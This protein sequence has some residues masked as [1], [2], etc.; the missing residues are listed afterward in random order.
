MHSQKAIPF[1][2]RHFGPH[3]FNPT[4][5]LKKIPDGLNGDSEEVERNIDVSWLLQEHRES[6]ENQK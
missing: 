2:A 3:P 5:M 4:E 6:D 1:S